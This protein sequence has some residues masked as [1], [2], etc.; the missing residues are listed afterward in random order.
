MYES[1]TVAGFCH[2]LRQTLALLLTS[3]ACVQIG[4]FYEAV[5]TDAVMCVQHAKLNPMPVTG[6]KAPRA[7]CPILNLRRTLRDLTS[8]GLSVV[9]PCLLSPHLPSAPQ[10]CLN[11]PLHRATR[12]SHGGLLVTGMRAVSVV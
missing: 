7:G 6:G 4:E 9:G 1:C 8:A 3:A 2:A 11:Q 5:G 12:Q 10:D